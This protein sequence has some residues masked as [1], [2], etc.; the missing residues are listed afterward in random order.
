[1]GENDPS[2][3]PIKSNEKS[4]I[5]STTEDTIQKVSTM[6]EESLSKHSMLSCIEESENF[7]KQTEKFDYATWREKTVID[8]TPL[9]ELSP[10]KLAADREYLE[11]LKN[12]INTN[13]QK[14]KEVEKKSEKKE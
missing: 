14:K 1:M 4:N 7:F 10:E 3:D 6:E 11:S 12:K 5:N 8:V 2:K 13:I 9:E